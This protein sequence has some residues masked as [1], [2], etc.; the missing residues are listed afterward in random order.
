MLAILS[1]AKTLDFET[2]PQSTRFTTPD[3]LKESNRLIRQLRKFSPHEISS[4]MK[5]SDKLGEQNF[6]R[7]AD[8]QL[9]FDSSNAKQA[10]LAFKG[11]VYQGLEAWDFDQRD[12]NWAQKHLR[13]LSGL[14]GL[15]RP[16]DLIQP[17]RLEMGTRLATPAG[18]DLYQFWGRKL[19]VAIDQALTQQKDRLLINLASREYSQA[20]A[21]ET[22]NC[23]IIT[24]TFKDLK[25]GKYKFMSFYGKQARGA[26]ARHLIKQRISSLKALK[27]F[28]G[29]GYR[30]S[31]EL[32]KG[33]DWVFLRDTPR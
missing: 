12:L 4:L 20:L 33:D 19:S 9:P 15:L 27:A 24:P 17:Y 2:P 1:P 22:L 18:Q 13:I 7:F 14:Y 31:D 32:S 29:L 30:Y 11:D 5:I 6:Q 3:F 25:Q 8:W 21:L 23:R 26:M 10:L 28:D 16:M